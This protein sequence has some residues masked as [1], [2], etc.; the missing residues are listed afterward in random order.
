MN[1]GSSYSVRSILVS[2]RVLYPPTFG[3]SLGA[4]GRRSVDRATRVSARRRVPLQC[5]NRPWALSR[6]SSPGLSTG[7]RPPPKGLP[8]Q[9]IRADGGARLLGGPTSV[10]ANPD[11]A[12]FPSHQ[13]PAPSS[14]NRDHR[15]LGRSDIVQPGPS[16][17]TRRPLQQAP[18]IIDTRSAGA[19]RPPDLPEEIRS[20]FSPLTRG[21]ETGLPSP[22]RLDPRRRPK[23]S[24]EGRSTSMTSATRSS[25]TRVRNLREG[26]YP[27][28]S[29]MQA[30]KATQTHF[31]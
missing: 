21:P 5:F 17:V 22:S 10:G 9:G 30:K 25:R 6:A 19:V 23:P 28:D 8:Q 11:S 3:G 20:A 24:S 2:R 15:S 18:S 12:R 26:Y 1:D 29:C 16:L 31:F 7:I 27:R 4:R 13:T 14:P